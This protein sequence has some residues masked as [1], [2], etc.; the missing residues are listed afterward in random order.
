MFDTIENFLAYGVVL[1]A[2][3]PENT[4]VFSNADA[5]GWRIA[6]LPVENTLLTSMSLHDNTPEGFIPL[7]GSAALSVANAADFSDL[8]TFILDRPLMIRRSVWHGLTALS[9]NAR[10][11]VIENN[12]VNLVKKSI[13]GQSE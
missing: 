2:Y 10:I 5:A 3:A 7:E 11:L 8:K 6:E 13:G 12:Q 1:R 9:P 4:E